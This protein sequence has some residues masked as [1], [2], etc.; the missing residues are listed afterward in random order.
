MFARRDL[1]HDVLSA[2]QRHCR[3]LKKASV[4]PKPTDSRPPRT[5]KF[6]TEEHGTD[7]KR[8]VPVKVRDLVFSRPLITHC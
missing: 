5:L 7:S 3:N 6:G 8:S 1:D 4:D 2:Y